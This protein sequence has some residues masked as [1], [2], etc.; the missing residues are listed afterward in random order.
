MLR[1]ARRRDLPPVVIFERHSALDI[2]R[3]A[4]WFDQV[5]C[6]NV[7]PHF[8]DPEQVLQEFARVLKPG[9]ILWVNHFEGSESLNNFHRNVSPAV[10]S[11]MLSD[12]DRMRGMLREAGFDVLLFEDMPEHYVVKAELA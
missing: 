9:G 4:A 6:L 11:H 7:F 10:S 5:I 3:P 1:I 8:S 2:P 12:S